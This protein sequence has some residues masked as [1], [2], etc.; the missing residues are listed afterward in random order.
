[1]DWFTDSRDFEGANVSDTI[2]DVPDE[3]SQESLYSDWL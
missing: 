2:M 3:A 1:M